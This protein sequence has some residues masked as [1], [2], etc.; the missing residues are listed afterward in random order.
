MINNSLKNSVLLGLIF[1]QYACVTTTE[2]TLKHL[3]D[4]NLIIEEQE[5][6]EVSQ[7]E[8]LKS[9]HSYINS[10][11]SNH[12]MYNSAL[13]RLADL[14][15]IAGDDK[16]FTEKEEQYQ[17]AFV[18]QPVES[19][20]VDDKNYRNAI[21]LY[22]GVLTSNPKDKRN[23][24]V[25]Y[26]LARAYE[27][28]GQLEQALIT[29]SRLVSDFP[30]S[31]YFV[32]AQF[33]K[34]EI[35]FTLG[36]FENSEKSLRHV[37]G[38]GRS[39]VYYERALYKY[40]WAQ[41]KQERYEPALNSFFTLLNTLPVVYDLQEKID[42]RA[43]SQVEK[44]MLDDIFRAVNLCFSYAGGVSYTERYFSGSSKLRYEY[45][46]FTRLGEH[47]VKHDRVQDGAD[48]YG[49][50]VKRNPYHPMSSFMQMQRIAAY[51]KGRF[52]RSALLAREEFV[53]KFGIDTEFWYR[54]NSA[55]KSKLRDQVKQTLDELSSFYH[56]RLQRTNRIKS[57]EAAVYWYEQYVKMFPGDESAA[58]KVF[59]L[60]ELYS[61]RKRYKKAVVAYEKAAYE[62]GNHDKSQ[63]AAYAVIDTY[64][65]ILKSESSRQWKESL[66]INS[67]RFLEEYPN[68][69]KADA[70]RARLIEDLYALKRFLE[71]YQQAQV[72]IAKQG[73]VRWVKVTAYIVAGHVAFDG[74][75]YL[76][77]QSHY[78]AA[79]KLG[80]RNKRLNA[81]VGQKMAAS[82]YKHAEFLRN[83]GDLAAAAEGFLALQKI[84]PRSAVSVNALYD[85]A[86][87][88]FQMQDWPKA[89]QLLEEFRLKNPKHKLLPEVSKKLAVAY[90]KDEKWGKA[91]AELLA[92]AS[93]SSDVSFS[94]DA[95]WQAANYY[96]KADKKSKAIS[97]YKKYVRAYSRPVLQNMEGQQKLIDLYLKTGALEKRKYWLK[98]VVKSYSRNKKQ[99]DDRGRYIAANATFIL[100]SDK[101]NNFKRVSLKLPL[102]RSLKRKNSLMRSTIKAY[103]SVADIG[104]A[105]FVT[106]S[107][108]HVGEVYQ[109][110][111]KSIM[112]SQRPRRLS[113][114]ELEEYNI[115]L[116]EQAYPF[117]EK[118]ISI[119]EIN[120]E[121]IQDG[122]YDTW[123]QQSVEML[124][125][126]QP[127]R[128]QKLEVHDEVYTALD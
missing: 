1:C 49:A 80:V 75:D 79:L 30:R 82:A 56:A 100:A 50:F 20:Q 69:K 84:A 4:R 9:Y 95:V 67:L 99:M 51:E 117:E 26:K 21:S 27:S 108:F 110:L 73:T 45:E 97:T 11:P 37:I 55:T 120:V 83:G 94:R 22:E 53:Q 41:F 125:Q 61:E 59:L 32:E 5:V 15:M 31:E 101:L 81:E 34:G 116:E 43:L 7:E 90:E 60:G 24:W 106:A 40:A 38:Q 72:I 35:N 57:F 62:Y 122:L 85:S 33:R 111:A 77:A 102:K 121:R 65:K 105:E 103:E 10:A 112:D 13:S 127:A 76:Q 107:T 71:A 17:K 128:Y 16:L 48:A 12:P 119:F 3:N 126:L 8:V 114:E 54:Q 123:I 87:A 28:V 36:D 78:S 58:G 64:N 25:L 47:F 68:D 92:L 113:Q 23:E 46:V 2:P 44:D 118:A 86:T 89:I 42:T 52:R 98:Q 6:A 63:V 104:V 115:L 93:V 70:V 14:E 39:T 124:A 109:Q 74:K 91:A 96:E 88:Y 29:L 19:E 18:S 66:V